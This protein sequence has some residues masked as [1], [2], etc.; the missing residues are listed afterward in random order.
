MKRTG[1]SC[2]VNPFAGQEHIR[3]IIPTNQPKNIVV[4]GEALGLEAAWILA[5]RGIGYAF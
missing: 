3:K 4:V 1:V 2:M 5:A